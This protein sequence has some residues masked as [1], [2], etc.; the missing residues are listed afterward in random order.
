MAGTAKDQRVGTAISTRRR[1]LRLSQ[2]YVARAVG[3]GQRTLVRTEQGS[4]SIGADELVSAAKVLRCRPADL[5]PT[6]SGTGLVQLRYTELLAEMRSAS[7]V[8]LVATADLRRLLGL[9]SGYL[10]VIDALSGR[11]TPVMA[12][13]NGAATNDAERLEAAGALV[14]VAPWPGQIGEYLRLDG[15]LY[16]FVR[17]ESRGDAADYVRY[18]EPAIIEAAATQFGAR[19]RSATSATS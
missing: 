3:I 4:R 9:P 17:V 13:L 15:S 2:R 19:W 8:Q 12:V 18:T 10:P 16:V 5:D 14:V 6:W 11:G 1:A 7:V